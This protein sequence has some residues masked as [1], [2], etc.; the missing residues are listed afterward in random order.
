MNKQRV[1][2]SL[3]LQMGQ[4]TLYLL[5]TAAIFASV[6]LAA[7]VIHERARYK[8][9]PI[10]TLPEAAGFTFPTGSAQITASF[11][12]RL[13]VKI[14]PELRMMSDKYNTRTIEVIGHTDEVPLGAAARRASNLDVSLLPTL[15]GQD[16]PPP[17]AADNPGLGMARAVAIARALKSAGIDEGF[18]IVPLSAG[19]FL[20]PDDSVT[21]GQVMIAE[22][23]RRRIEIRLRR[24]AR[25]VQAP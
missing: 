20:R 10:I 5:L 1:S 19:P 4:E 25:R 23:E 13:R 16:A 9:P 11:G 3:H 21:D 24:P 17:I 22:N 8:E 12:E 2:S 15:L 7:R 14:V 6:V 18:T